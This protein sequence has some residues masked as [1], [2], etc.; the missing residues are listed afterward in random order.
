MGS[1]IWQPLNQPAR[2]TGD[3]DPSLCGTST[4]HTSTPYTTLTVPRRPKQTMANSLIE[5][6]DEVDHMRWSVLLLL[7]F[8]IK[9]PSTVVQAQMFTS[10]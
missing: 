9:D 2:A 1:E 4:P 3:D 7:L 5:D 8:T 10:T 6:N